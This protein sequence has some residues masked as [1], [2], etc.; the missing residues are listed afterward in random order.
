MFFE[1]EDN[2]PFGHG[3]K[4]VYDSAIHA[5]LHV[6]KRLRFVIIWDF[7]GSDPVNNVGK[8]FELFPLAFALSTADMGYIFFR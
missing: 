8:A 5:V 1:F 2:I 3:E 6:K 4:S 7:S